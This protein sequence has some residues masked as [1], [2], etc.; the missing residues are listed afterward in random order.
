M[1]PTGVAAVV[2]YSISLYETLHEGEGYGKLRFGK[3]SKPPL[4][5]PGETPAALLQ[6]LLMPMVVGSPTHTGQQHT[7]TP[8]ESQ[9]CAQSHLLHFLPAPSKLLSFD[10]LISLG[11]TLK[12]K[13]RLK[14]MV[15]SKPV[16]VEHN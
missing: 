6:V 11:Q 4:G 16:P 15:V 12:K 2:S 1:F 3:S 7:S 5:D 8:S 14:Q 13:V 9:S 10:I